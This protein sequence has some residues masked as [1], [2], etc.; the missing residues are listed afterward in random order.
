LSEQFFAAKERK[1]PLDMVELF[2]A[3]VRRFAREGEKLGLPVGQLPQ[4]YFPAPAT[5]IYRAYK[6]ALLD[7]T[8]WR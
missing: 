3:Y 6:S 1:Q 2:E 5:G 4:G 7:S 8:A